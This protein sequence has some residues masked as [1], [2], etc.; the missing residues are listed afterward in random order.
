MPS[1]AAVTLKDEIGAPPNAAEMSFVPVFG[2]AIMFAEAYESLSRHIYEGVPAAFAVS[3]GGKS[4]YGRPFLSD[5]T[6]L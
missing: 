6:Q 4:R 3:C 1:T 2:V 5:A